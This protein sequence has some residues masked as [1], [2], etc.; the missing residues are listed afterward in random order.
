MSNPNSCY[1]IDDYV[2]VKQNNSCFSGEIIAVLDE[3]AKVKVMTQ[4]GSQYQKWPDRYDVLLYKWC[5]V[6]KK[7]DPPVIISNRVTFRV[8]EMENSQQMSV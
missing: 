1:Q 2:V 7:I 3:S 6:I 8:E 4:I 5:N